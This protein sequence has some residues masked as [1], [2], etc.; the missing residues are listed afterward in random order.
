MLA[1][2]HDIARNAGVSDRV[3]FL[4]YLGGIDKSHAYHAATFL[5][6]PS[7][8]EAMSIVALE[9]GV[10]GTPV[11]LTD[12][13]GFNQIADVGGGWVVPATI[14]GISKGLHQVLHDANGID[15]ASVKIKEYVVENFS[16]QIVVF[17]YWQLYSS[18]LEKIDHAN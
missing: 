18:M 8:H 15:R 13:C 16:W 1:E 9:A 2:L 5:V 7:R 12:Q 6:I 10:S 17:E 14:E 3:H 11:L 4:G